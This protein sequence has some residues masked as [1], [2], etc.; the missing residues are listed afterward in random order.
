VVVAHGHLAEGLLSGLARVAGEQ[1]H[2]WALS[3]D[4]RSR[5]ALADDLRSII[6]ERS[7]GREAYLF[8]D[9]GGGSCGQVASQLVDEGTVRAAF[10]GTNLPLLIEFVF[11]A[12]LP[13]DAFVAAMVE[14][15]QS[16]IGVR[17]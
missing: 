8:V 17:R 9:L 2:L 10:F 16:A 12:D 7:E 11:L 6:A 13:A 1:D 14:K 5:E 4:G 15:S 3:N